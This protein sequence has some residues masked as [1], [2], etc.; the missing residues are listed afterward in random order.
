MSSIINKFII[1]LRVLRVHQW[2]KNI[3][4]FGPLLF[5]PMTTYLERN[6]MSKN[7]AGH[8]IS[9]RARC[10]KFPGSQVV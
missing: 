1:Y 5:S 6:L 10:L 2:V 4:V 8:A 7:C 3:F 9:Y